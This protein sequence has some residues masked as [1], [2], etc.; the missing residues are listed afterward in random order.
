MKRTAA[1]LLAFAMIFALAGCGRGSDNVPVD[2]DGGSAQ[3]ELMIGHVYTEDS[4]EH[5]QMLKIKELVE[6][7]RKAPVRSQSMPTSRSV[8]SNPLP[9]SA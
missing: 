1:Y 8:T 5:M 3:Y 4:L 9:S 7:K 2:S 6:E